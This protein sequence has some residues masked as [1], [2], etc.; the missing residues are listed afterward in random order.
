MSSI[1]AGFLFTGSFILTV[2]ASA[3]L[4]RR[5]EQF[6]KWLLLSES[7]LGI[8][9]ALGAD[10]PEISSAISAMRSG[11]HDLG[12]GIVLGSN[13]F[14]LAILLGGNALV[15]G[16]I[17]VDTRT[18]LLNGGVA[19]GVMGLTIAQL[20]GA[21]PN[22][23]ALGLITAIMV[24]YVTATALSPVTIRKVA[25]FLGLG[26]VLGLTIR[27]ANR[28]AAKAENPRRPSYADIL[29][30]LPTLVSI[31]LGSVGLVRS[32]IVLGGMW[33]IS[34]PVL[35]TIILAGL[36]GIPNAF[37]AIQLARRGRGSA[38]LSESLNSNTLNLLVGISLPAV[39]FGSA[40]LNPR[41]MLALWWLAGMTL[42]A[43][44]LSFVRGGL[45]RKAG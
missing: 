29:D 16:S 31:V 15:S 22:F 35:G 2:T 18:L 24:P 4:S 17:R 5:I 30:V 7:L 45:G 39:F 13:I 28:D 11:N 25:E 27:D 6:G 3:V 44:G 32:A 8:I 26:G 43:L 42:L 19:L 14:N 9:A 23:W 1:Q 40:A 10:A 20:Y 34:T 41:S 33:K 38:V 12:L 21:L 36:T 37:T